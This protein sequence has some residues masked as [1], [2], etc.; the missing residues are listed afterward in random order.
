MSKSLRNTPSPLFYASL[1]S[2]I[3]SARQLVEKGAEVNAQGGVYSNALQVA[4]AR[5]HDQVVQL[6]LENGADV[7]AQ[8]GKYSYALHGFS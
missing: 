5:S 1:E 4:S 6:L 3:E 2:L 7:N 8:G